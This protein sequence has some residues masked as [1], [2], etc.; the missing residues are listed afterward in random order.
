MEMFGPLPP[1]DVDM[2]ET[3]LSW[4]DEKAKE[5]E[6]KE[7]AAQDEA[8]KVAA[9]A[10][11]QAKK[12]RVP[13]WRARSRHPHGCEKQSGGQGA[14]L[15]PITPLGIVDRTEKPPRPPPPQKQQLQQQ[16]QQRNRPTTGVFAG[17]IVNVIAAVPSN[18]IRQIRALA[19]SYGHSQRRRPRSLD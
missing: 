5:D 4:A 1:P 8:S 15:R 7:K 19:S 9:P 13:K 10:A 6:A 18:I 2:S 11:N 16:Q 17:S 14:E 12:Q 3:T